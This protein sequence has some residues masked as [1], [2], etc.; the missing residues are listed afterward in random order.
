M[1]TMETLEQDV[2]LDT[3]EFDGVVPV[4]K[5]RAF[6][7]RVQ[8]ERRQ[9]NKELAHDD[10]RR[11]LA[12]LATRYAREGKRTREGNTIVYATRWRTPTPTDQQEEMADIKFRLVQQAV[13]TR[14]IRLLGR[15]FAA[16]EWGPVK[17]QSWRPAKGAPTGAWEQHTVATFVPPSDT[18]D[19]QLAF[20]G[21]EPGSEPDPLPLSPIYVDSWQKVNTSVNLFRNH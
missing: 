4:T 21:L 16:K 17:L 5:L 11:A 15:D 14:S 12:N 18:H 13:V 10:V 7:Q 6:V 2:P 8:T 19:T 3:V 1:E 20:F 9:R